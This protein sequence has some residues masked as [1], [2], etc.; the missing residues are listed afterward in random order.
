MQLSMRSR[1]DFTRWHSVRCALGGLWGGLVFAALLS[2][3]AQ[4][5]EGG[6]LKGYT[7]NKQA[8]IKGLQ[9]VVQKLVPP[10]GL[11]QHSQTAPSKP[12][13]VAVR[14]TVQEKEIEVAPGAFIWAFTF[15]NSVPGPIIVVHEGDYVEL[16]LVNPSSNKLVHNIDFHASTGALGGAS[17]TLIAP[18]QEVIL[19]WKATKPGVFVYHCAPSGT[20]IP[21]HVVHGMNGVVMVLPREGLRDPEGNRLHYDRAYYLGEQDLYLPKD[22]KGAYKRY[23]NAVAS[24]A[25]DLKVMRGLIPTHVVFNGKLGSLT[26]DNAMRA[27]V[28]ERVLFIHAQANRQSYPHLIG[29]HGDFVWERGNFADPPQRDL[30]S[31]SI[32]AGSAS[33]FL[34][35][36]RQPGTYVYLS[37]NLIEAVLLGVLAH[38]QVDGEWNNDLM[39][40]IYS[41]GKIR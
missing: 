40:Q 12:R 11:P 38:V 23:P 24:L 34:Y 19:R 1:A 21:W 30:E 26:G 28:G 41:P 16:T 4:A 33:A 2:N 15:N 32:A 31:W 5:Y 13:I 36:F 29:G 37:H 3:P 10:P 35:T 6:G 25:D 18:G 20:M 39:E 22:A 7:V 17:L 8:E 27:K 9:R 14:M